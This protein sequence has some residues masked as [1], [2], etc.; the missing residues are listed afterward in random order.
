M[1]ADYQPTAS[2]IPTLPKF[3]MRMTKDWE[4]IEWQ[5]R[6][7]IENYPNRKLSQKIGLYT[8]KPESVIRLY[9]RVYL[10]FE[11]IGCSASRRRSGL[12]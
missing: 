6:G 2:N 3:G 9:V 4:N 11:K 5:G 8:S 10:Y 1:E 7:P 12:R